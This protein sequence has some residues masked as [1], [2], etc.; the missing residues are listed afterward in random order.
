[1]ESHECESGY[2]YTSSSKHEFACIPM[3]TIHRDMSTGYLKILLVHVVS[4]HD[5]F[6]SNM[7][8]ANY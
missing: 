1:M 2:L 5:M 7:Y 4:A 3:M 6:L 8:E